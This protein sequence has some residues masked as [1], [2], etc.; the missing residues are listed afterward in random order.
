MPLIV[1]RNRRS[2]QTRINKFEAPMESEKAKL[3][4]NILKLWLPW[5]WFDFTL[6]AW[7]LLLLDFTNIVLENTFLGANKFLKTEILA[8]IS[9]NPKI[10]PTP[11]TIEISY[12]SETISQNAALSNN[13]YIMYVFGKWEILIY[14]LWRW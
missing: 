2:A 5:K 12:R 1:N 10:H 4:T 7:I 13:T 3:M 11:I 14:E 8:K 6:V 9:Y